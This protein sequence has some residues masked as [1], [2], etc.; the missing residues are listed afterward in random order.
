MENKNAHVSIIML[1]WNG[2]SDTI[3]CLESVLK[4]T[5]DN[6]NV[7]LIDNHSTDDSLDR[8]KNWFN[9]S[10][11]NSLDSN[12]PE[13]I[14]PLENKPVKVNEFNG[15]IDASRINFRPLKREIVLLKNNENLGFAAANNQGMR[16][17]EK[18]F[19]S[20]YHYLLN[21]DTVIEKDALTNLVEHLK[22]TNTVSVVQSTI[23]NYED[24]NKIES[25][26]GRILFWGQT[27]YY[28][29]IDRNKFR[30]ISFISGCA[31]FIRAEVIKS[32]G[33][34]TEL[35]FHGEEDFELSMRLK[36]NNIGVICSG[37]S[38][39]YHKSGRSVKKLLR[40]HEKPILLF[41][42]N[43]VVD[44]KNYYAKYTWSVWR[45]F[46]VL[47]FIHLL[48]M[49]SGVSLKRSYFLMKNVYKYTN[50]IKDVKKKTLEKIFQEMNI[51]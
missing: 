8:I 41:A 22:T 6:Y 12:F 40:D 32:L 19:Q 42:L 10:E 13:L 5:Y 7:I 51:E 23:F 1:N 39:V 26:G 36:K 3:E 15:N 4:L 21:N 11:T 2:W 44:L 9:G 45:I 27:K 37:G 31:L 50:E 49:R 28:K 17:A 14:H 30:N 29:S 20:Q 43:R 38:C 18:L 48:W 16:F 46:A 47:Y 24:K 25:A 33:Y 35:F 34:L